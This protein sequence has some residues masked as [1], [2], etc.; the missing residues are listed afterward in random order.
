MRKRSFANR[1]EAGRY[2][3]NMRWASQAPN[4]GYI[5]GIGRVTRDKQGNWVDAKGTLLAPSITRQMRIDARMRAVA[6]GT[7]KP[8]FDAEKIINR[9][10]SGEQVTIDP[11]ML[12]IVLKSMILRKD[13]PDITNLTLDGT[14]LMSRDNLGIPRNEM[15]Q[16]PTD[17]KPEFLALLESRGVKVEKQE[18]KASELKPIQA[19]ISGTTSGQIMVRILTNR[20]PEG[21]DGFDGAIVVSKD[22]YVID[23][24]HRWA[25]NVALELAGDGSRKMKVL[26]IDLPHDKLIEVT[27]KWNESQGIRG[28]ELGQNNPKDPDMSKALL[29]KMIDLAVAGV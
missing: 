9:I 5:E 23:G 3:A 13:H 12:E 20:E 4:R 26:K 21:K 19:N 2:A 15:P 16:I 24:H 29:L 18:V 17:K 27:K 6:E 10:A 11:K 14:R 1:S 7:A 22:D 25:A 8:D 28:L